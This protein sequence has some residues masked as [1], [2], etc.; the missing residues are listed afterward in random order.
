MNFDED[1]QS[2][3]NNL[4]QLNFNFKV[5]ERFIYSTYEDSKNKY[6]EFQ[7]PFLKILKPVHNTYNKKKTI[8]K[9]YL[10]LETNDD[11]DFDN[12]IGDF[13]FIINKIHELSQDKIREKSL[14]WFNTEFDDIGLDLKVRRPID[15]QKE[16]EFIKIC[17]PNDIIESKILNME[18][19]TYVLCNIIF[20]GLKVSSDFIMEELEIV[21]ILTQEEFDQDQKNEMLSNI[22]EEYK[23]FSEENLDLQSSLEKEKTIENN[24]IENEIEMENDNIIENC[25]IIEE[26]IENSEILMD[27][28]SIVKKIKVNKLEKNNNIQ[29]NDKAKTKTIIRKSKKI[30]FT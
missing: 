28:D 7:T 5:N 21:S 10:I 14:E 17:I 24:Q 13:M 2:S 30:I 19:G 9:K 1:E 3:I 11:L 20:K 16:N 27:E 6:F 12:Q 25:N 8:A 23:I 22:V 26:V 15:Q 18:K 29:K 4:N